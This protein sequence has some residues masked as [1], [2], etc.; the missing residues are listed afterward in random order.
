MFGPGVEGAIERY[1]VP[2]RELLC[3]LQLFRRS[4]KMIYR[5]EIE[6]GKK[7]FETEVRGQPFTLHD[8]TVIAFGAKGEELFRTQVEEPF[9]R[10][11][12]KHLNW[13]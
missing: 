9:F 5:Y 2:D 8:D 13:I 6:E 11:P 7:V 3:V 4:N 1:A 12:N 10:R